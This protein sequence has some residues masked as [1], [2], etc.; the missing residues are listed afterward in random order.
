MI[1]MMSPGE[2]LP[3]PL[4]SFPVTISN[5]NSMHNHFAEYQ[6]QQS[7]F[8]NVDPG[9]YPCLNGLIPLVTIGHYP[10]SEAQNLWHVPGQLPSISQIHLPHFAGQ[11]QST[12]WESLQESQ[13][14]SH[15]KRRNGMEFEEHIVYPPPNN[16]QG[17]QGYQ[18]GEFW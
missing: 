3:I 8:Q 1:G 17:Y 4:H 16:Q 10:Q 14:G 2:L 11:Q 9:I 13:A 6:H 12:P 7:L 18:G 15:S 5:R